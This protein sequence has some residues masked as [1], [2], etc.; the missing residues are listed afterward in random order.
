M[1]CFVQKR[2]KKSKTKSFVYKKTETTRFVY[3]TN[4]NKEPCLP[5]TKNISNRIGDQYSALGTDPSDAVFSVEKS[6]AD[7][8]SSGSLHS[9]LQWTFYRLRL[10]LTFHSTCF[11]LN[12]MFCQTPKTIVWRDQSSLSGPEIWWD[13]DQGR[14][15]DRDQFWSGTRTRTRTRSGNGTMIRNKKDL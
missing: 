13:W 5:K 15:Q 11:Y 8:V 12:P 3:K 7:R 1:K 9:A 4:I 10:Y 14:D 6:A 2:Y